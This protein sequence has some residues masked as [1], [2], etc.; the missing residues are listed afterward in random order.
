MPATSL[1]ASIFNAPA[2]ARSQVLPL[3]VDSAESTQQFAAFGSYNMRKES[4]S[5]R[6]VW[7]TNRQHGLTKHPADPSK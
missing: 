6:D 1:P 7:I 2:L 3:P 4:I 5:V